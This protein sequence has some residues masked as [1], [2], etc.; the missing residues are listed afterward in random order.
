ML[1]SECCNVSQKECCS[2]WQNEFCRVLGIA[3]VYCRVNVAM[4]CSKSVAVCGADLMLSCVGD[5]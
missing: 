2:L 1:Q 3:E 4:C 5:C